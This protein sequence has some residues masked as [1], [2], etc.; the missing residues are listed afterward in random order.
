[1]LIWLPRPLNRLCGNP[2]R[3][4]SLAPPSSPSPSAVGNELRLLFL[5]F[6]YVHIHVGLGPVPGPPPPPAPP[7]PKPFGKY[8]A[9]KASWIV[10]QNPPSY[11]LTKTYGCAG[12]RTFEG[13]VALSAAACDAT[14]GCTSF[15]VLASTYEPAAGS[16]AELS[17]EPVAE[18]QR[19]T[20]WSSWQKP[21]P[22]AGNWKPQ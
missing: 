3:A 14:A 5:F 20:W 7:Q 6:L 22:T 12:N 15:S 19:N 2:T 10:H 1:M 13:C 18:G 4:R 8:I 21:T 9:T 16:H 17:P 11:S